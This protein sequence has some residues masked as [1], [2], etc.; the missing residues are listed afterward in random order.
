[1]MKQKKV[2]QQNTIERMDQQGRG[3]THM[4][5]K[6]VFV[7]GAVT[8]ETVTF[9]IKKH[10]PKYNEAVLEE[11][12][13]SSSWREEHPQCPH[14]GVCGGCSLQHIKSEI[15]PQL[16]Q[17]NVLKDLEHIAQ[18]TPQKILPPLTGE[19]W[20]YRR[21]AR[22]GVR[23]VRKKQSLL[24]GF[25]EKKSSYLAE[26]TQ[27]E[28]LHPSV[29]QNIQTLRELITKLSIYENIPQI[30][31][32]IGDNAS[33][34][35]L[36]HLKNLSQNDLNTLADFSKEYQFNLCLQGNKPSHIIPLTEVL[37][38]AN[39]PYDPLFYKLNDYNLKIHFS[40][41]DFIQ[42]NA[43]M[44]EQLIAQA[45]A[46]LAP[47]PNEIL[48]ELFCGL[49][50]FTLPLATQAGHVTGIEGNQTLI[51]KAKENAVLNNIDNVQYYVADLF[52]GQEQALWFK[53]K[54]YDKILLDPPRTGAKDI[55]PLL[56]QTGAS[57]IL[58]VSCNPATLARDAGTL[59]D[60]GYQ[61]SC[62]GMIDMFPH[63]THIETMA[64]FEKR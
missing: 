53:N 37:P 19:M 7:E 54:Q 48:L 10:H 3:I 35:V 58:Y 14:F 62:I 16:K 13:E 36:R 2:L 60:L 28:I 49:G 39:C 20:G 61:L 21:K 42:I 4:D 43:A 38:H 1:M 52:E 47:K 30:E 55:I 46:L 11:I 6:V 22:L 15:Q 5:G 50:N 63:T 24:V 29:G 8:G 31:V 34:L 9:Y 40:P 32:A 17:Q 26:L 45:M 59:N 33:T 25:R 51:D 64:L 44:N 18:I 27:C 56:P 57:R 12:I 23:Y 41:T